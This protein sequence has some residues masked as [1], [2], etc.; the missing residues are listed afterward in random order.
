MEKSKLKPGFYWATSD[1]PK[2]QEVRAD[3]IVRVYGESPFYGTD[4][5]NLYPSCGG[6][7]KSFNQLFVLAEILSI[8][9]TRTLHKEND[10]VFDCRI[11]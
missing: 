8:Q 1:N 3:Y 7:N 6:V 4:I 11:L 9:G 2:N 10:T 5:I